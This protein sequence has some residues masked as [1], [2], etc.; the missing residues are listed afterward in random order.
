VPVVV[1]VVNVVDVVDVVVV[2]H[3]GSASGVC[4]ECDKLIFM[5]MWYHHVV[6]HI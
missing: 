2:A 3:V 6:V 4:H 1:N 5:V